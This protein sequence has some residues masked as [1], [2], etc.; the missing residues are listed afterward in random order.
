[1]ILMKLSWRNIWRNKRRTLII[2]I[3]IIVGVAGLLLTDAFSTGMIKQMLNNNIDGHYAHIQIYNDKYYDNK[4]IEN[5]IEYSDNIRSLLKNE[6]VEAYSERIE[7]F[8]LLTSAANSSGVNIIAVE[9]EKEKQ[10]S[11]MHQTVI[12]G[13]YLSGNSNEIFIGENL[14]EKLEV[15]VG[16]K[17]VA[18]CNAVDGSVINELFRVSGIF[19]SNSSEFNKSYVYIPLSDAQHMLEAV[20]A[21]TNIAIKLKDV[22]Q[23]EQFKNELNQNLNGGIV[24]KDYKELLPMLI[25]M[26]NMYFQ[27]IIIYYLIIGFAVVLGI[28]NTTLMSVFE[29]IQ[30]FGVLLSIGMA[31]KSIFIMI[32]LESAFVGIIGSLIGIALGAIILIPLMGSGIDLSVFADSLSSFGVG[33]II[34]P[35]IGTHTILY[36]L[37]TIPVSA[38]L[39]ALYPAIKTL[40]L[41]PTDAMRY[42]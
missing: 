33:N 37:F 19:K 7:I 35:E 5:N 25:S 36:S 28:I 27:F 29:R 8:G 12:H 24:A 31:R 1:M 39:G 42:V 20:S 34:Y 17:L 11:N 3:S 38:V 30:E 41:Q 13:N 2:L 32:L 26:I 40:K 6:K 21:I 14:A 22:N 15:E 18:V 9:P 23:A 16:D 10:V 4:I